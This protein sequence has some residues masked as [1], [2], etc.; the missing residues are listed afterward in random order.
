LCTP[1]EAEPRSAEAARIASAFMMAIADCLLRRAELSGWKGK[2]SA[3]DMGKREERW[4]TEWC[5]CNGLEVP[6]VVGG[7]VGG[8]GV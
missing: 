3:M 5:C 2:R 1:A 4:T 8:C 7:V 6:E